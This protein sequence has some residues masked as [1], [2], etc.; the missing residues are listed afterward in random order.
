MNVGVFC[1]GVGC[2]EAHH[3]CSGAVDYYCY[4]DL[5]S[6]DTCLYSVM[7]LIRISDIQRE[8]EEAAWRSAGRLV[9]VCVFAA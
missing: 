2:C 9:L 1:W 8:G 5:C 7:L 4:Y 3:R 6:F